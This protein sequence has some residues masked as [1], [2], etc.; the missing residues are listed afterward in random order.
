[1]QAHVLIVDDLDEPREALVAALSQKNRWWQ[2]SSAGTLEEARSVLEDPG[3][4]GPVDLVL[5]DLVMGQNKTGGIDVLE[6]A[7]AKDPFVMVIVFTAQEQE[8]DRFEAY[9]HGAFD[10]VEKNLMG[11]AAWR[12]ISVKAN[13]ALDFR[14]QTVTRVET[15]KRLASLQRFFDARLLEAVERDPK[16]LAV[17]G[18]LTTVAFW[19]IRGFSSLCHHL[20]DQ[21]DV[22]H[23]FLF[24]YYT[25]TTDIVFKH[26]GI[27]DKY[28]GDVVMALFCPLSTQ[29]PPRSAQPA[30]EAALRMRE[31]FTRVVGK[32]RVQWGE[33]G[34]E[35]EPALVCAIHHGEALVG[36]LGTVDREQFTALGAHVNFAY[37]LRTLATEPGEILISQ[38]AAE[39]LPGNYALEGVGT[40]GN[41]KSLPDT[42][43]TVYRVRGRQQ[44]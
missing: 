37:Q 35:L 10:C 8:L 32:W 9:R 13:A 41:I 11:R 21:P 22:L 1:M 7:K 15:E 40:L 36:N 2:I 30:V 20:A 34:T 44:G 12:E 33:Q 42:R 29:D 3:E 31:A 23:G 38:T 5:T 25:T 39:T 24:D 17:R 6:M 27:L 16:A 26:S 4:A 14:R 43:M 19:D 18:R 28:M